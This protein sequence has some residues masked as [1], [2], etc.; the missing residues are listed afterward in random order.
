MR[1]IEI[2]TSRL[3]AAAL[4]CALLASIPFASSS[5]RADAPPSAA[6]LLFERPQ[7]KALKSG[8]DLTYAYTFHSS[9]PTLF[10]PSFD[11]NIDLRIAPGA[12][13]DTRNVDV[14][15]FSGEHRRPAGPFDD[16]SSNPLLILMLEE[17]IQRLATVF[18]ANPQ[19]MKT[20]IRLALRNA[21]AT[22]DK[23]EGFDPAAP[24]WQ[25]SVQPFRD[26]P[27]K[28]R[29]H[30]LDSLTYVFH[31]SGAAPGEIT[32]IDIAARDASGAVLFEETTRYVRKTP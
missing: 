25:V 17:N 32:A 6:N 30:G 3:A 5:A 20:A 16:V 9:D 13:P 28:E 14:R 2:L 15:L 22:P 12:G 4:G 18:H 23:A 27:N 31:V 29:M 26:D 24:A 1:K 10:G 11:D 21:T 8:D 7:L 19:Y